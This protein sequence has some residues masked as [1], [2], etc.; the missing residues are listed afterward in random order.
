MGGVPMMEK[1]NMKS[2]SELETGS[3]YW[4]VGIKR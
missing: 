2:K 4:F 3:M 1:K